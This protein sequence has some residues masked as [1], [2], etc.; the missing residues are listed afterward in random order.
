MKTIIVF[1][2]V[3][4][5]ALLSL[6]GTGRPAEAAPTWPPAPQA[7]VS[8]GATCSSITPCCPGQGTCKRVDYNGSRYSW[9]CR[10]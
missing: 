7:C 6:S 2:F 9:Q 4:L 10:P 5:V 1:A 8:L 3:A